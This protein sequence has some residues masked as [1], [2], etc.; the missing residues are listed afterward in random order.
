MMGRQLWIWYS[1]FELGGVQSFLLRLATALEAEGPPLTIAAVSS[2]EGPL[3]RRLESRTRTLDWTAFYPAYQREAPSGPV[4]ERLVADIL[5]LQPDVISINGCTD[6]AIGAAPFLRRIR[7]F[8]TIIDVF[9][10]E[11]PDDD[12]LEQR[13]PYINVLDG[14]ITTSRTTISRFQEY[15]PRARRIPAIYAPCGIEIKPVERTPASGKLRIL[16]A[17]RLIEE[18]KRVLALPGIASQLR[19]L[20]VAFHLTVV[21]DGPEREALAREFALLG[22]AGSVTLTGFIDPDEMARYYAAND[23]LLNLSTYEGFAITVMEAFAGGCVPVITDLP[24]LD[25]NLLLDGV[26]CILIPVHALDTIAPTLQD[27]TETRLQELSAAGESLR[28][29][30]SIQRTVERQRGFVV[31]LQ[32]RRPTVPWPA[33]AANVLDHS[34][35]LSALNPWLPGKTLWRRFAFH[36]RQLER[37]VRRRGR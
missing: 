7:P 28:S 19:R 4:C 17:G 16:Y 37:H 21:G 29:A 10:T 3:R 34:W 36:L 6:F 20:G 14:V 9:H 35:D 5:E 22:L 23:V 2:T 18:Q 27:L 30:L 1:P 33:S 13:M 31:E 15:D 8:C 32:S 11:S 25:R 26:N 12:F 24:S